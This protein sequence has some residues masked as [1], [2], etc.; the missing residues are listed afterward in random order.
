MN[1]SLAAAIVALSCSGFLNNCHAGE[2]ETVIQTS[3]DKNPLRFLSPRYWSLRN[4]RNA[5]TSKQSESVTLPVTKVGVTVYNESVTVSAAVDGGGLVGSILTNGVVGTVAAIPGNLAR[6]IW[7]NRETIAKGAA[8]AGIG[9]GGYKI[10]DN[11]WGSGSGGSKKSNPQAPAGSTRSI[12][13]GD[14]TRA[15]IHE[16]CPEGAHIAVGDNGDAECGNEPQESSDG[17]TTEGWRR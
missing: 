16:N 14:G 7:E 4:A 8:I 2:P 17:P 10:Y 13:G 12:T 5:C 9:Y 11:N 3:M 1:K 15:R 6:W